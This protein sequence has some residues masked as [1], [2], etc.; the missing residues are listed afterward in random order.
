MRKSTHLSD[1]EL[2]LTIDGELPDRTLQRFRNHLLACW[3]CRCRG[4]ELEATIAKFVQLNSSAAKDSLP[5]GPRSLFRARLAKLAQEPPQAS[6]PLTPWI[7]GAAGAVAALLAIL[8]VPAWIHPQTV[9]A[10][11][12]SI[13]DP[14]LTPGATLVMGREQVCKLQNVKNRS[15]SDALKRKVFAN[16]GIHEAFAKAYEVDYLITPALGGAEDVHN[17]WPQSYGETEWNAYAKDALEDRLREL[18]CQGEIDLA[19]AQREIAQNW[20]AAYKK[21]VRPN[22]P[23]P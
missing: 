23:V 10:V 12:V 22:A 7:W 4:Q 1:R 17:L 9:K 15:V 16:Y 13:P 18:V 19:T 3:A 2:L 6:W 20:I 21:Y 8:V 5:A 14:T 11:E